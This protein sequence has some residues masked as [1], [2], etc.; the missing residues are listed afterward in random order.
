M[1]ETGL[2][3]MNGS[4]LAFDKPTTLR[5]QDQ[6]LKY[7]YV[8]YA[9]GNCGWADRLKFLFLHGMLVFMQDTPCLEHYTYMFEPCVHYVPI[10]SNFDDLPEAIHW[11]QYNDDIALS[12]ALRGQARARQVLSRHGITQYVHAAYS[13]IADLQQHQSTPLLPGAL[14]YD[15]AVNGSTIK[16]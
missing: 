5:L 8:V 4:F 15:T 13:H 10:K 14:V 7:K 1:N 11:A 3:L 9:E 2:M 6:A 16:M 12:I